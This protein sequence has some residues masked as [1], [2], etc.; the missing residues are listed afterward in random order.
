M[1][2]VYYIPLLN[3]LFTLPYPCQ[4]Q[5]LISL[6]LKVE[7]TEGKESMVNYLFF[8]LLFDL[9]M[10]PVNAFLYCLESRVCCHYLPPC[11]DEFLNCWLNLR[12]RC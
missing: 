1:Y 4:L 6:L 11:L 12:R 9:V 3:K 7:S 2:P 5:L 10:H 8:L